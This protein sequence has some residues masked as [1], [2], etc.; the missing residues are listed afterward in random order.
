MAPATAADAAPTP[1]EPPSLPSLREIAEG[2]LPPSPL[3][4]AF[5]RPTKEEAI[6]DL[7]AFPEERARLEAL[8]AWLRAKAGDGPFVAGR[9][10]RLRVVTVLSAHGTA[11]DVERL[12]PAIPVDVTAELTSGQPPPGVFG[13][14]QPRAEPALAQLLSEA[15]G[16]RAIDCATTAADW[17]EPSILSP[18]FGI[19]QN[20]K[21][22]LLFDLRGLNAYVARVGFRLD[23]LRDVARL[24]TGCRFFGR[25]DLRKGYFQ[26]PVTA[27]SRRLLGF[28]FPDGRTG[29][30][31]VLPMGL[32]SAP[33]TFQAITGAFATVWRAL[34][35]QCAV[36]LDD[37]L[38][39]APS[40]PAYVRA[41]H[42]IV[43]D[44]MMAGLMLAPEKTL[45]MPHTTI[46][47]LGLGLD[48][49]QQAF[50]APNDK[51]QGIADMAE[52]AAAE[53]GMLTS[54]AERWLGRTIFVSLVF[55]MAMFFV[56]NI[57]RDVASAGGS[58][59]VPLSPDSVNDLRWW[60]SQGAR[61][62][63]RPRPWV[64]SCRTTR[65]TPAALL[66]PVAATLRQDASASG[67]GVHV[68]AD[69]V[70]RHVD[71]P[72]PKEI[73][74]L[75]AEGD[76]RASSTSR[77][78]YGMAFAVLQLPPDLPVG[79]AVRSVC[80]NSA[81]VAT[82]AGLV[83]TLG[84]TWAA[85]VL[86][87]AAERRGVFLL[88]EW[89]PRELLDDVDEGSRRAAEDTSRSGVPQHWLRRRCRRHW[90]AEEPEVDAF[91][92]AGSRCARIWGSRFAEPGSSGDGFDLIRS[93][94]KRASLCWIFPPFALAKA[95]ARE[96]AT[97]EA[98]A[99]SMMALLPT[100]TPVEGWE[101]Y[102]G[103]SVL[104]LPGE[105]GRLWRLR[106][107]SLALWV[108]PA[109]PRLRSTG[110]PEG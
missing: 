98:P 25:A 65:V 13:R 78:I 27:A 9:L 71:A 11:I 76:A 18:V 5:P 105:A 37:F 92:D 1:A 16:W 68:S 83:P 72:L 44:L 86:L 74:D 15:E 96:L 63:R 42:V 104:R 95:V 43:T 85:R 19:E 75:L 31:R 53:G 87:Y 58:E 48:G 101:R 109:A 21:P 106:S 67:V 81:A 35:I 55:P 51:I 33:R 56:G 57:Y 41:V 3:D 110:S 28:R 23:S 6:A 100:T 90:L 46:R 73:T 52:R 66:P 29:R 107:V 89:A 59:R 61:L 7:T 54:D 10:S 40:I 38:W 69:G 39:G 108:G 34:G 97:V 32:S 12:V 30:W 8:G 70:D 60:A 102:D 2:V 62:L 88:P 17:E 49:E 84:T 45:L 64:F 50:F 94:A 26:V 36:Y 82:A 80:D 79:A 4:A 47:F 91:A 99:G 103:P 20:G 24:M 93:A 14:T 77:E 22:R